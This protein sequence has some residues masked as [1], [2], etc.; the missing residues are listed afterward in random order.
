MEEVYEMV[1]EQK[2]IYSK[3]ENK[4]MKLK[5]DPNG[6]KMERTNLKL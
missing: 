5:S 3:P 4:E 6:K 1:S 2:K